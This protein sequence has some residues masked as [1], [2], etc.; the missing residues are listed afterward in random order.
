MAAG[1]LALAEVLM[2]TLGAGPGSIL[3]KLFGLD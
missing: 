3:G 2:A 1:G